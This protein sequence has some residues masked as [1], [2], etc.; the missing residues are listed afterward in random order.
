MTIKNSH[1]NAS[2]FYVFFYPEQ[3]KIAV[4]NWHEKGNYRPGSIVQ[5]F[6]CWDTPT[7]SYLR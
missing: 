5:T 4:D 2:A 3:L 7:S 1:D 6:S